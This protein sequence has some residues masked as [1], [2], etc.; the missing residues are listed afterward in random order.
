MKTLV[1]YYSFEGNTKLIAESI[2]RAVGAD[3][4]ALKPLEEVKTKGF[5]KFFWGGRQI[6]M[7]IK[8]EL[9]P[10]DRNPE[11]YDLIF[12]GTPVWAWTYTPPLNTFFSSVSLTG[13]KVAFFCCH[14]GGKGGIFDKMRTALTGSTVLGTMDFHEP[15]KNGPQENVVKAE[16]WAEDIVSAV[17]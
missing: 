10:L 14:G 5:M 6:F 8:P 17:D 3:I 15:L 16:K 2:A 12:I 4:L 13:R 9:R 7:K 1:V 11:D